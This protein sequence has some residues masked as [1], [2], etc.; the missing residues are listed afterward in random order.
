MDLCS[1]LLVMDQVSTVQCQQC[2]NKFKT[3]RSL[4][5]HIRNI[6]IRN[7]GYKEKKVPIKDII[8]ECHICKKVFHHK[9]GKN[10]LQIHLRIH[11]GE[12]P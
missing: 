7:N 11:T 6:H 4:H 10:P 2:Q 9:N 1:V 3:L 8:Y 5:V 12:K